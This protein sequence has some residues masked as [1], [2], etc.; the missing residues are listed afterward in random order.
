M[1]VIPFLALVNSDIELNFWTDKFRE[2]IKKLKENKDDLKYN[3]L[4]SIYKYA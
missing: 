4:I 2:C 3:E 1:V